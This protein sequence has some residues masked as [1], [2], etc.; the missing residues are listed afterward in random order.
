ML[1]QL[2]RRSLSIAGNRPTTSRF[3]CSATED[4]KEVAEVIDP[5]ASPTQNNIRIEVGRMQVKGSTKKN[6]RLAQFVRNVSYYMALPS[7]FMNINE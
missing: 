3:M 6:N 4:M 2:F 5:S 1:R 7:L